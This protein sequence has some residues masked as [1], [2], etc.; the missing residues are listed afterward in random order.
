MMISVLLAA[1]GILV[2][3]LCSASGQGQSANAG[4]HPELTEQ[5]KLIACSECHQKQTPQVYDEWYQSLH[6]IGMV[7]CYQCHGT[8]E[9]MRVEPDKSSCAACHSGAMEKCPQDRKCWEC[10]KAHLFKAGK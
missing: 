3:G 4:G 7:K 9:N 6:G 8:F 2:G 10:H 1:A 5:E